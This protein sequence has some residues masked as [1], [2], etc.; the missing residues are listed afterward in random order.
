M[1]QGLCRLIL[2]DSVGDVQDGGIFSAV[3]NVSVVRTVQVYVYGTI[4]TQNINEYT[5]KVVF[6]SYLLEMADNKVSLDIQ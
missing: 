5:N 6:S 3:Q 2:V 1:H 4:R